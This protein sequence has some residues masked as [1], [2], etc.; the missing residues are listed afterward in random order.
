MYKG[1]FS[2]ESDT[3]ILENGSYCDYSEI[4]EF[5]CYPHSER[6]DVKSVNWYDLDKDEHALGRVTW[7]T[8]FDLFQNAMPCSFQFP[9]E[10]LL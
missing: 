10:R 3:Y 1:M 8:S 9:N 7:R 4:I 5:M 2:A 6:Y